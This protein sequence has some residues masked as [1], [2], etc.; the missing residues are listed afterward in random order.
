MYNEC[1]KGFKMTK[2]TIIFILVVLVLFT[3]TYFFA[4]EVMVERPGICRYCHFITPYYNKWE[5]STHSMVPCLKCHEYGPIKALLG[6]M[7]FIAGTHNP[8][9]L[10]K[11]PD[12]NCLQA[13]C[14]ERRLIE[15]K[16]SFAKWNI[17]FDHKP[18]FT[19][20]RRGI[21]LH[22]RSCHSDIVQGEH[23]KVSTNVCFICH[24]SSV[25][26][27][28][29]T[30]QC[31]ICHK[32][33]QRIVRYRGMQFTHLKPLEEGYVCLDCHASVL[34]GSSDV[35][36]EKCFFCHIDRTEQYNDPEFVHRQH[37]T[38][39]QIDCFFAISLYNMK[40]FVCQ[41]IL[42]R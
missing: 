12:K 9:P 23:M 40:T 4:R 5:R 28:E 11:V 21:L 24:L 32:E 1:H 22:C 8:R 35:P 37:V 7:R 29:F 13:G 6:Q 19:E 34:I 14:H 26:S 17:V 39:K 10:T 2:I 36:Q 38:E 30:D 25:D 20:Q 33:P 18:H 42:K 15:S 3:S 41:G 31:K 16:V 27:R